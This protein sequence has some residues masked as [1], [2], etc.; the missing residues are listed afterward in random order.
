MKVDIEGSEFDLLGTAQSWIDKVERLAVEVHPEHGDADGLATTLNE[1]GFEVE[2][3][4]ND[5]NRVD[6]LPNSGGYFYAL[7][8][9]AGR[10]AP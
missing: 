9:C 2:V 4:D 5:L 10:K 7:R 1:Y 6:S 3:R 8:G